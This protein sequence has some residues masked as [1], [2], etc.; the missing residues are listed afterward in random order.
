M[1]TTTEKKTCGI[2]TRMRL[3]YEEKEWVVNHNSILTILLNVKEYYVF[4]PM[5]PSSCTR[6]S[7][8]V[9]ENRVHNYEVL[10]TV[11]YHSFYKNKTK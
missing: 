3:G 2:S 7:K 5:W 9:R 8:S 6:L 10:V 4:R 11:K 1:W